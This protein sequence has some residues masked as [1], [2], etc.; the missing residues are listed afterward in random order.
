MRNLTSQKFIGLKN[1]KNAACKSGD[2]FLLPHFAKMYV[3]YSFICSI[4]LRKDWGEFT[5]LCFVWFIL[6][7]LM[8]MG[9][10]L[11]FYILNLTYLKLLACPQMF[12]DHGK[13]DFNEL[14]SDSYRDSHMPR[15]YPCHDCSFSLSAHDSANQNV[16][17]QPFY[18][19]LL[20]RTYALFTGWHCQQL[21]I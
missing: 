12:L 16:D 4:V 5:W 6:R 17:Y 18:N 20:H 7:E 3:E 11:T 1:Y 14:C 9:M 10:L 2:V 19:G 13:Q 21:H 15:K 8:I